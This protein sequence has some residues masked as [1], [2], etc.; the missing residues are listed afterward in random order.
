MIFLFLSVITGVCFLAHLI[1]NPHA[2]NSVQLVPGLI[3]VYKMLPAKARMHVTLRC[4]LF[5]ILFAAASTICL[6]YP[7]F[8]GTIGIFH[9]K[10]NVLNGR[11]DF[12][13]KVLFR[14]LIKNWM[15]WKSRLFRKK[16]FIL[17]NP[18]K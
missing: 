3:V 7:P 18:T 12:L 4:T 9:C 8:Y 5:I 14:Y 1:C 16:Q 6:S 11:E 10:N 17:E 13:Q 2:L 15:H